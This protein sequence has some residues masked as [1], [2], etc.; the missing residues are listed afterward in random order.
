LAISKI[1][2]LIKNRNTGQAWG[3]QTSQGFYKTT[4]NKWFGQGGKDPAMR[5][6]AGE[7]RGDFAKKH[8]G[9]NFVMQVSEVVDGGGIGNSGERT[10]IR[11]EESANRTFGYSESEFYR[12][13]K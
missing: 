7:P 1:L 6:T 4:G 2:F 11:F 12:S 9:K 5:D 3:S 8:G 13:G 10:N